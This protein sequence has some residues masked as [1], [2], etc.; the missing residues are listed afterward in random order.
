MWAN[1]TAVCFHTR[2][3]S[4]GNGRYSNKDPSFDK[5]DYLKN[6]LTKQIKPT[7][8]H[9]SVLP[10]LQGAEFLCSVDRRRQYLQY[11]LDPYLTG[12]VT[13]FVM[14]LVFGGGDSLS[15]SFK[16][17][18]RAAGLSHI[19]SASGSNVSLILSVNSLYLRKKFG[20]VFTTILATISLGIYLFVAG[21]TAPLIRASITAVLALLGNSLWKRKP[22]QMWLLVITCAV[23]IFISADYL[24]DLSF[25]LSVAASLG[26]LG[27][28][29]LFPDKSQDYL[30]Q[31]IKGLKGKCYQSNALGARFPRVGG[32][33]TQITKQLRTWIVRT[34]QTTLAIQFFTLP[35]NILFFHELSIL[36][37][38]SNVALIWLVPVIVIVTLVTLTCSILHFS[39]VAFVG[40]QITV[41]LSQFFISIVI[42]I[43]KNDFALIHLSES[44]NT[45][46]FAIYFLTLLILI[47]HILGSKRVKT[48][49]ERLLCHC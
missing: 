42:L 13:S 23:M 26:L 9:N 45:W 47:D 34:F 40:G 10:F 37:V 27:A 29:E 4:G 32:G 7:F 24:T 46:F 5:G 33:L 16:N 18:V 48:G 35:V 17:H 14:G 8:M 25:Q 1:K 41:L 15:R 49:E 22:S 30:D 44:Q 3:G 38:V 28:T 11:L 39:I 20:T 6:V 2:C 31:S 43:G 21:C 12:E 36:A 19:L